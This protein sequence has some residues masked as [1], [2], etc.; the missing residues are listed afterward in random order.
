MLFLIFLPMGIL[1]SLILFFLSGNIPFHFLVLQ[2]VGVNFLTP[3]VSVPEGE[4]P[5]V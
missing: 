3:I 5:L 4:T 1:W 2:E